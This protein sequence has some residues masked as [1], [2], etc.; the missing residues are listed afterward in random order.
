MSSMD[1]TPG[2]YRYLPGVFQY[3][4][5]V[6]ALDGFRIER[7]M[8]RA[9]VPLSE[10]FR[11]IESFLTSVGRPPAALCACELR[12]PMQMSE[13]DFRAFNEVYVDRLSQWGI[14]S[15]GVN[16]VARSNVCPELS[17]PA[18]PSFHAFSFTA[19]ERAARPSF[20]IAGSGEVPEGRANYRDH[21]V[22]PGDTSPT[23]MREKARYVLNEMEGR[24]G[25]LGFQWRDTT[26]T[27]IY[28]VH[29]ILPL[30]SDEIVARGAAAHGLAWHYCRPPIV[31]LDY[32]MDC[33][34]IDHER[35][36]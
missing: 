15:D 10:G 19:E 12:S 5:G 1:F 18:E 32:E 35:V 13:A 30:L 14:A 29:A 16:P 6:A 3:S 4:A 33:R 24:L 17:P 22:R 23:G 11:R 9:P 8:F 27:Q 2:G 7:V 28:T 31:G 26:A 36:V 20:V 25:G 21:I 34:G